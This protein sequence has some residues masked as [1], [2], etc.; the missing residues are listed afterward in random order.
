MMPYVPASEGIDQIRAV[1]QPV[2]RNYSVE[3]TINEI[4]DVLVYHD[5]GVTRCTYSMKLKDKNGNRVPGI[6]NGKT[7][8]MFGRQPDGKWRIHYDC[9][10]S[11]SRNVRIP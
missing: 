6:P 10:N 9:S 11:N 3:L 7:L 8:T 2:F 4:Q 1:M 5:S